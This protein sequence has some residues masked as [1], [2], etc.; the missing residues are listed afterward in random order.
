MGKLTNKKIDSVFYK[1]IKQEMSSYSIKTIYND[2]AY[3][4]RYVNNTYFLDNDRWELDKIKEINNSNSAKTSYKSAYKDIKFRFNDPIVNL[5][6]KYVFYKRLFNGH[7]GISTI[8]KSHQY[9]LKRLTEFI[10]QE[11]PTL[12]SLLQ[13]NIGEAEQEFIEW[14]NRKGVK[15]KL[16]K[17]FPF[18]KDIIVN[19]TIVSI[20]RVI[21]TELADNYYQQEE[22]SK[23]RWDIRKLN[24]TYGI[25]YN[26]I[27]TQYY[28]N[29]LTIEQEMMRN[30][31]K[32]YFR[33]RLL[34]KNKFSWNTAMISLGALSKFLKYIF[35]L[36]PNWTNIKDLNRNHIDSYLQY[37]HE[38][39]NRINRKDA[40]PASYI[41]RS[42]QAVQKFLKD[43]QKYRYDS[44]PTTDISLLIFQED[45]PKPRKKAI[46]QI[47]YIPDVVLK[48]LFNRIHDLHPVVAPVVWIAFKT[49]LRVSDV[50][51]LTTQC[52]IQIDGHYWLETDLMKNQIQ[53]HRIPIDPHLAMIIAELISNSVKN[54][55][56]N[57]K[58]LLFISKYNP[59]GGEPYTQ[60]FVRKKLN[61]FAKRNHI[62]DSSGNLFH[63]RTH[64][65]RHTYAVKLINGGADLLTVQQLLGHATANMTLRYA[66]LLDNTK[67]DV[68]DTVVQKGIFD[69]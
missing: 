65:F 35:Q 42:L 26:K 59:R 29:F 24:N 57:P 5:E 4:M 54:Q 66:K 61:E 22:W 44:A 31:V 63:F 40:N 13:L 39:S 32:M 16:V 56:M 30:E 9:P 21:L 38:Y 53:G 1:R 8:F 20:I 14:L 12:T 51:T 48:Q 36:E 52:L 11:Y 60:D 50:L 27:I 43:L 17:S 62:I 19:A 28:L 34:G 18:N 23:D 46:S 69:I 7:W 58:E 47:D 6:V 49:G 64:Q 55:E 37:L 2:G 3:S 10:N 41:R 25:E 68:F 67:R 33:Q 45:F 15:T